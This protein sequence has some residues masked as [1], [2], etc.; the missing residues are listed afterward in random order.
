[1]CVL[2][3][4]AFRVHAV[5]RFVAVAYPRRA[6]AAPTAGCAAWG[7]ARVCPVTVAV[8]RRVR[9]RFSDARSPSREPLPAAAGGIG[10]STRGAEGGASGKHACAGWRD[11]APAARRVGR[12]RPLPLSLSPCLLSCCAGGTA[13]TSN[14]SRFAMRCA[15]AHAHVHARAHARTHAR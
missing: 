2:T 14:Q 15:H 3:H 11:H 8:A 9:G 1:M 13:R 12:P 5:A 6:R 10:A 4:S 7:C